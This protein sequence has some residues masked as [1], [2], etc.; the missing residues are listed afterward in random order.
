MP[1]LVSYVAV[2]LQLVASERSA[3]WLKGG[4][5]VAVEMARSFCDPGNGWATEWA[6]EFKAE[7]LDQSSWVPITSSG[8]QMS[9]AA[10]VDKLNV[11][12]CRSGAC[13]AENVQVVGGFLTLRSERSEED[14]MYHT[15]A[16]TT[17]GRVSWSDDKPYRL[18]VSAKL[19]AAAGNNS[20]GIWPAIWM[21]P[22]TDL[23]ERCLDEGEVDILEMINGDGTAYSTYH[24]MSSWPQERCANFEKYHSS[25]VGKTRPASWAETFHEYAIERRRDQILFVVDGEIVGTV[26][27]DKSVGVGRVFSH[28]P[29]Y[30]TINTAIGGSWPGEP[31][32]STNLPVEHVIDYVRVAR[33]HSTSDISLLQKRPAAKASQF[34][35]RED[36]NYLAVDQT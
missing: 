36:V 5:A 13:R 1:I 30:L 8:G 11:T 4:P 20:Q 31:T 26:T 9:H 33:Q 3:E 34:R 35:G 27:E 23:S 7:E 2:L 22:D 25:A 16:V 24:W 28:S 21:L 29:F 14:P 32:A 10:P 18:C 19:P 12:A 15:A 17:K 6:D